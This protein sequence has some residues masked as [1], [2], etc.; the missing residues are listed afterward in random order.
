MDQ[1]HFLNGQLFCE[2]TPVAKIAE[3]CGTPAYVYSR[4]AFLQKYREF[5]NAFGELHPTICF[6]VKCCGN[7]SIL[8]LLAAAGCGFDVTSGGELQRALRAGGEPGKIIYAGVG[9]TDPE[10]VDA[11]KAGIA[12]FNC[13]SEEEIENVDRIAAAMGRTI[14]GAVRVNPDVDA[15]SHAK[16]TTG[17]KQTK[18]GVDIDRVEEVFHHFRSLR[19]LRLAGVHIHIGSPVLGAQ[20]YVDAVSK[21][22]GLIDRLTAKGHEI[23]WLDCGGG[24][25]A[26]Y[27]ALDDGPGIHEFARV[28]VPLL[29]NKPYKIAFE[30][31]RYIAANSGILLTR[32]LYRKSSGDRRFVIV[33]A[34]MNDLL[35]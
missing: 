1:F 26:A 3:E 7:L 12:A 28:L 34:G 27:E 4:A 11:I 15:R 8:R 19:H 5:A 9:K 24:F 32:V 31:G 33:D 35:R 21:A 17:K 14:I 10:I 18:F 20:P 16:T 2:A 29:R 6:S 25:P 23:R 22:T 13:E 30:P